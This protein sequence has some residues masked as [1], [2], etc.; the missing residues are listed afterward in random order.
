MAVLFKK[1]VQPSIYLHPKDTYVAGLFGEF[2]IFEKEQHFYQSFI[3]A[4]GKM[5]KL[6]IRPENSH[7]G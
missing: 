7:I 5:N 3:P 4:I 2:N 1:V 6:L